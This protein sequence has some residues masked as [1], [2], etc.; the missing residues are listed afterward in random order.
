[1]REWPKQESAKTTFQND[2]L[3]RDLLSNQLKYNQ[4]RPYRP[5]KRVETEVVITPLCETEQACQTV[6]VPHGHKYT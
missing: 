5:V 2:L 6:V 3:A 4:L 1:M